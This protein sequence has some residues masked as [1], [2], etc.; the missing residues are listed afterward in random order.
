[1]QYVVTKTST[2]EPI[3][4]AQ[5]PSSRLIC[6]QVGGLYIHGGT[7]GRIL[8]LRLTGTLDLCQRGLHIMYMPCERK[9]GRDV[10]NGWGK[11][12]TYSVC[13]ELDMIG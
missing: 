10:K 11:V 13:T 9:A 7:E 2:L 3:L 6:P 5:D 4:E 1:M 8:V 12:R